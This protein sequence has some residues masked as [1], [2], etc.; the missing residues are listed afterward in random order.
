MAHGQTKA[1]IMPSFSA[2]IDDLLATAK[3]LSEALRD[4]QARPWCMPTGIKEPLDVP[5][6]SVPAWE[7]NDINQKYSVDVCGDPSAPGTSGDAISL[8]WQSDFMAVEE[9]AFR[10]RH[11]SLPRCIAA[12]HGRLNGHGNAAGGIFVQLRKAAQSAID[13]GGLT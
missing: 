7:R 9:R 1:E 12:A 13:D 5:A 11:A 6:L 10:T 3:R 4:G 2:R 8:K